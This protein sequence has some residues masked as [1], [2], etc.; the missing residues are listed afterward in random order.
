MDAEKKEVMTIVSRGMPNIQN[1]GVDAYL[2]DLG[3]IE[4]SKPGGDDQRGI[5]HLS[6][7][8]DATGEIPSVLDV[9]VEQRLSEQ[10]SLK[11]HEVDVDSD[12]DDAVAEIE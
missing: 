7:G 6:I 3:M 10:K 5:P 1:V 4:P 11:D 8:R 12:A 9:L 2:N